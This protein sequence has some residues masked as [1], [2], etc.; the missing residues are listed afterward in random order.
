MTVV[1]NSGEINPLV[2][3]TDCFSYDMIHWLTIPIA[4]Y[5]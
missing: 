4:D 1:D 3:V 5:W 2:L